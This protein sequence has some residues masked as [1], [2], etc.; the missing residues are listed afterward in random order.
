VAG[1]AWSSVF[2]TNGQWLIT[3]GGSEA[4]LW[5]RASGSETMRFGPQGAVAAAHFSPTGDRVVTASW[6]NAARIWDAATGRVIAKLQGHTEYVNDAVFSRDGT[7]VLT[8]S[9][10]KTARLWDA[11]SSKELVAFRGHAQRLRAADLYCEAGT[12]A[13]LKVVTASDDG[14]ARIWD[15]AG[16]VLHELAG[17]GGKAVLSA[18]FS[19]D[20]KY[21]LTGGDD[22][23]AIVWDAESGEPIKLDNGKPMVLDGHTAGVTSVAFSPDGLRAATGSRDNTVKL[24][25]LQN[26]KELLTLKGHNQEVTTVSFSP[27]RQSVLSGSLDGNWILWDAATWQK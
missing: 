27:D 15:A 1:Q 4:R 20:G 24:W 7:R 18:V 3:V 5:D 6:D 16:N 14:S 12:G 13:V 2:S 11:G 26:G 22:N 10:D 19:A 21:V 17:H 8:A 25:E 23:R 9:D